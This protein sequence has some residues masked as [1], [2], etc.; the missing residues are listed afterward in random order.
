[1]ADG[2]KQDDIADIDSEA[3][4]VNFRKVNDSLKDIVPLVFFRS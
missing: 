2:N 4:W 3:S 1:M